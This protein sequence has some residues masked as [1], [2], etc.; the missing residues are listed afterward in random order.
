M[1]RITSHYLPPPDFAST[2]L[3]FYPFLKSGSEPA[4]G[5]RKIHRALFPKF[6]D[7]FTGE[8]QTL[9]NKPA[10]PRRRPLGLMGHGE[11][12]TAL[13]KGGS[14]SSR[15]LSVRTQT[16]V[17]IMSS[18]NQLAM[19]RSNSTETDAGNSSSATQRT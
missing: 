1:N 2:I 7:R 8:R 4:A 15:I 14:H 10:M 9:P 18:S 19:E 3:P 17:K 16:S 11:Y 6:G 13:E 12:V 5:M